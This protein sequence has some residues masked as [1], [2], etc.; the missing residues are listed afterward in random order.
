MNLFV[1]I[2]QYLKPQADVDVVTPRHR[3]WLDDHYRSGTFLVSGRQDP[4]TGG[5]I[6]ARAQSRE[7][8]EALMAN[9]P[10]VLEG[11]AAYTITAFT[12]VKRGAAVHLD[13]I[14]L[15]Q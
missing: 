3:A 5:V 7:A 1:L 11:C 8:L 10:F 14:P 2:S 13:D 12:P 15:V 6:V 9:D 4:P